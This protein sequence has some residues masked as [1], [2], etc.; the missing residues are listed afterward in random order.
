MECQRQSPRSRSKE[1]WQPPLGGKW[2]V[3]RLTKLRG[4]AAVMSATKKQKT[5]KARCAIVTTTIY[6]R[7]PGRRPNAPPAP[8]RAAACVRRLGRDAVTGRR[9]RHACVRAGAE[10]RPCLHEKRQGPRPRGHPLRGA[11][12]RPTPPSAPERACPRRA[13]LASRARAPAVGCAPARRGALT[14]P[15]DR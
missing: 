11:R 1:G 5:E 10:G 2:D 15:G 9:P 6:V 13:L 14:V 7:S 8:A 3:S 4:S 12:P